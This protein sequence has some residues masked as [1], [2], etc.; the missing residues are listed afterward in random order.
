MRFG[1]G[2]RNYACDTAFRQMDERMDGWSLMMLCF[3]IKPWRD[4][5]LTDSLVGAWHFA[6]LGFSCFLDSLRM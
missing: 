1:I 3:V 4:H 6:G 2:G 5:L